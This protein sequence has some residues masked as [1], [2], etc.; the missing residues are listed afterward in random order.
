MKNLFCIIFSILA[1]N[2]IS[3]S[4]AVAV[5]D[6]A[7][8]N[9]GDF[10]TINVTA[11]DY[12]PDGLSFRVF[13]VSD[14]H[15]Y[16]DSTVTYFY[17]YDNYYNIG[18]KLTYTY[19]L[20]DENDT[21]NEQSVGN[22]SINL[23]NNYS[24]TLDINNIRA[25]VNP[26]GTQFW[27]GPKSDNENLYEF[28]KGSGKMTIF[29]SA[30]WIGGIDQYGQL[31]ASADR[32]RHDGIDYWSGPISVNEANL[33]IDTST[34]INWHR[35]WKLNKSEVE[36]HKLHWYNEGYQP[37]DN[38]VN[39]P[40]HGDT[41]LNQKYYLAPFVD[42]DE[43]GIYNP[44]AGDYPLIKGDQSVFFVYNDLR[45]D[46]TSTTGNPIGLEIHGMMYQFLEPDNLAFNNTVFLNYKIY[47]RSPNTLSDT[48]IG[49]WTDCYIGYGHD[50]Y[51]GC[52]VERGFHYG[53]NGELVDG[54]GEPTA[55]GENPPAQGTVFLGGPLMNPNALDDLDGGCD[56]SI[57][58]IGFG[59]G[60]IDNERYGMT[61]HLYHNNAPGPQGD[62]QFDQDYYYFMK[63]IWKDGTPLNYGHFG[64]PGT[65]SYGPECKF[66][67][68]GLT[69]SCLWG[70]NGEQPNGL[71]DWREETAYDGNPFP[72]GDRRNLGA[73]GPFTFLP[74]SMQSID[75][76]YVT[77]Q[78]D[79]GPLS[80]VEL[81][82]VY[83]DT[84]RARYIKNSDSFGDQYLAIHERASKDHQLKIYPNPVG[85]FLQ[86]EYEN[87]NSSSVCTIHDIYGRILY[88]EKAPNSNSFS[89]N[90]SNLK[91]GVY[92]VTIIDD[93]GRSA[94]RLIKK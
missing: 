17:N 90:L 52:D 22:I 66:M 63:G 3:Q 45:V 41:T 81:L 82:K 11:N 74:N 32:Y 56:E 69:D 8:V 9:L 23:V 33:T 93:Y 12:H 6:S 28:P 46:N 84:I 51:V 24:D 89:I 92:V 49:I 71:I 36:Y 15:S 42:V 27:N 5:D 14:Y 61:S 25:L 86:V 21:M 67:Y 26:Y 94:A 47:N 85:D 19:L 20:I 60:I 7:T 37:I 76:A 83:V 16:T 39:W 57:N 70:T 2:S 78:G 34:V 35:V 40:A 58:G 79:N 53:Y 29:T 65:G 44:F 55:Y 43:N 1:L 54:N 30:L 75:I 87:K 10:I 68:P 73:M 31:K 62:P 18:G 38:I 4:V 59:D 80:S 64:Y 48:Y 88:S 91:N 77:A 50:D 13:N 72:A